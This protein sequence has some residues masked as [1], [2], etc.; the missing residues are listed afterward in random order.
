MYGYVHTYI[1]QGFFGSYVWV[2]FIF[3]IRKHQ[4]SVLWIT[5]WDYLFLLYIDLLYFLAAI[6]LCFCLSVPFSTRLCSSTLWSS[7]LSGWD[8]SL[9]WR[10]LLLSSCRLQSVRLVE[11][12]VSPP[13]NLILFQF[14]ISCSCQVSVCFSISHSKQLL[15]FVGFF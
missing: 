9:L 15:C 12:F 3:K 7:R 10:C 2:C 14:C 4:R 6:G 5:I 1:S 8:L 13:L 11:P